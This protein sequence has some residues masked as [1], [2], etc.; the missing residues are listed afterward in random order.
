MKYVIIVIIIL[1]LVIA[2]ITQELIIGLAILGLGLLSYVW[3]IMFV[4]GI[5]KRQ[6]IDEVELAG[7]IAVG[8]WLP[9]LAVI[10]G[11]KL[12]SIFKLI[13]Y[14]FVGFGIIYV[15]CKIAWKLK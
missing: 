9:I 12:I 13:I 14:F 1:A 2:I 4:E 6:Y 7:R 11:F 10:T 15:I 5:F 3:W 8:I